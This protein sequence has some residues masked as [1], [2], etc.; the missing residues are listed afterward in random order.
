VKALS[1][2]SINAATPY[3]VRCSKEE[4]FFEFFTHHDVH[5]S[6]GF[7]ED[8]VLMQ[9]EAYQLIIGNVNHRPSPRDTKVRDTVIGII[10]EFFRINNTTLLY[11]CETGDG[12]QAMRN[13]LFQYW[14]S[15]YERKAEF[16]YLSSS[17]TDMEG[18]VNYA[19]LIIRNDNPNLVE[20]ITQFTETIQLLSNKPD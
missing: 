11:I 6:V 19:T 3:Q 12:K 5:Y 2:E 9:E 20:V 10:D 15:N 18:V 13:R 17:I 14:F 7:M 8:D 16:T 4:G 1:L